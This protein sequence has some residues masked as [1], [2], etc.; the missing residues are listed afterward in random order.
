V[1][2]RNKVIAVTGGGNG[3]GREL[4]LNL[5]RRGARVAA[6]DI[7]RDRLAE[8]LALAGDGRDRVSTHVVDITERDRVTALPDGIIAQHG[9]IDGVI[10]NA[11][12]IQPFLRVSDLDDAVI[13]KVMNVNFYGSLYMTRAFLPHLLK[14]PEAH[15]VNISSMGGFLPVPGQTV[16]GASKAAIKLFTEGLRSELLHTRVGVTAVFPGAIATSLPTNSGVDLV[17]DSDVASRMQRIIKPLAPSKAARIIINGIER[18]R[19]RVLVGL[20]SV[21]M[22]LVYR[23]SPTGAAKLISGLMQSLLSG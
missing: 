23:M 8:T 12:I 19:Y 3:I 10:N 20:D 4:V 15:I 13:E 18:D 5:V 11:G 14:R 16:Y 9:A 6:I 17:P 2:V 21:F 1:K 7:Q 22:D